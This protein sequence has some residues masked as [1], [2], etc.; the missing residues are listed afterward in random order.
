LKNS[1]PAFIE[2]IKEKQLVFFKDFKTQDVKIRIQHLKKLKRVL[3]EREE[4][5][6]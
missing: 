1:T 6:L 4:S 3:E 5:L 2:N